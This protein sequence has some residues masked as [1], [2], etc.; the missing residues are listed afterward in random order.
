M[1]DID[2]RTSDVASVEVGC[3]THT[4]QKQRMR[5]R[6][7]RYLAIVGGD[8]QAGQVGQWPP[9]GRDVEH[10]PDEKSD[11][12]MEESIGFDLEHE[13]ARSIAPSRVHHAT[14]V[15]I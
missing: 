14:T 2:E 5:G 3:V 13:P 11:H 9:R 12:V 6:G 1:E 8:E 10:C 4:I 15:I 7:R